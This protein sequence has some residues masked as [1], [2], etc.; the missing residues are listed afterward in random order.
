MH[1]LF[2]ACVPPAGIR[3]S[4]LD[5]MGGVEDARWQTDA[6]L[7]VTL[8]FLGAVDGRTADAVAEAL[9]AV[10]ASAFGV[11]LRGVGL[12]EKK[13]KVHSLWAGLSPVEPLAA[14]H[15]RIDRTLVAIGLPPEQ[16][17]YRPHVTLARMAQ[18]AAAVAP[19]L[20][21]HADLS[22]PP[23]TVDAFTLF[24]SLPTSEGSVY[25][26]LAT[27]GLLSPSKPL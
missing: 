17:A 13:G 19:F 20:S 16:R 27:Y 22:S 10:R 4:P 12:F 1:R 3:R 11:V 9:A 14:L 8:R 15:A 2:V 24:E 25:R 18:P 6:Q 5:R 7:H 23:Y 21:H 26:P